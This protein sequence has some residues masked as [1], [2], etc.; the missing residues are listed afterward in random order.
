M[1]SLRYTL[2]RKGQEGPQGS[3]ISIYHRIKLQSGHLFLQNSLSYSV[4][5]CLFVCFFDDLIMKT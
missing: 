2:R 1:K 4:L 5:L 3:Y